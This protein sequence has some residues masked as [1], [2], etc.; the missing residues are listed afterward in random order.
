MAAE[1]GHA[2]SAGEYILHH[3]THFSTGKPKGLVDFSVV[4]FDSVVFSTVIGVLACFLLWL[5][6]RKVTS[7]VPGRFQ[8]A[9]E[10]AGLDGRHPQTASEQAA[11]QLSGAT[12]DLQHGCATT[13]TPHLARPVDQRVGVRRPVTVI[14]LGDL[15]EHLAVATG[16]GA[17]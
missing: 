17:P 11:R 10:F 9:V 4:N 14:R 8:A 7:G 16:L 12:A 5:A 13:E 1:E 3:V 6:A 2:L 15:V